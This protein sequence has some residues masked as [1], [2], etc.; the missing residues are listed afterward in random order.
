[1]CTVEFLNR[2]LSKTIGFPEQEDLKGAADALLRLQDTYALS[3]ERVASG[4]IHKDIADTAVMT[5]GSTNLNILIFML[6]NTC[7]H[8]LY[9][10][11]ITIFCQ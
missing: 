11:A 3:T 2:L 5:G 8:T 7:I 4:D 10:T 1:M 9:V 6:M